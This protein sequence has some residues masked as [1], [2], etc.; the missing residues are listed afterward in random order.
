MVET[1]EKKKKKL[2]AY[3]EALKESL[4]RLEG[5][6]GVKRASPLYDVIAFLVGLIFA[7]CHI[8]FGAHPLAIALLAVLPSH[9]WIT[10][11]GAITGALTLG[12]SGVIYAMISVILV[13]L[14]VIVSG[15]ES[16]GAD[17]EGGGLKLFGESLILKM[18]VSVIGGFVGAVYEVLI[19]G[20]TLTSV[21]FGAAMIV[22]P[23]LIV[24]A[25]SGLFDT[26]ISLRTLFDGTPVFSVKGKSEKERFNLL[27]FKLSSLLLLFLISLSLADLELFGIGA[28]YIFSSA[29]TLAAARRFGPLYGLAVG[30]VTSL[31]LSSTYAVAFAL[32]GAAA[33]ILNK[34]PHIYAV[35]A[36][37]FA[38]G[39]WSIY[40]SGIEGLLST[41]PEYLIAA[42][43]V[44]PLLKKIGSERSDTEVAETQRSAKEM[45]G[46][47]ALSYRNR[48]RGAL[49]SLESSLMAISSSVREYNE[50]AFR[51]SREELY[52]LILECTEKYCRTCSGYGVCMTSEEKPFIVNADELVTILYEKGRLVREEL[53]DYTEQCNLSGGVIDSINRAASIL[54]EEKFRDAA[55]DTSAE[56]FAAVSKLINE[57]RL[58]DEREKAMNEE[59]S[60]RLA[61]LLETVGLPDGVVRAFGDRK[62]YFIIAAEDESGEHITSKEL[63]AGIERIADVKLGT[64]EFYRNGKMA[65]MEAPCEKRFSAECAIASISA[66]GEV[67][68]GDS[69]ASF[70]SQ[71]GFFYTVISDGMGTGS[72]AHETADFVTG[73]LERGLEFNAEGHTVLKILNH[74]VRHRHRECSATVD[75]FSVDLYR[76]DAHF[77]KS[78]AAPSYIKRASSIFRIKSKT[79]PIGLMKSVDAERIRVELE[80]GD[81]IVMLSDGIAKTDDDSPWLLD[82]LAEEP[83]RNP[84]ELADKILREAMRNLNRTDD[85]TVA[86]TRVIR[87]R[88]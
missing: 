19:A 40:A 24:F 23:P 75:L 35:G 54:T 32:L 31:G 51:P 30:F 52:D 85:M 33:G 39:A 38:V 3:T 22:S 78:G 20:F 21:L 44:F 11:V 63:K 34:L 28:G 81:Y 48:Y 68:S 64:P 61:P 43:A 84:R 12:G 69:A 76:G 25:L 6:E 77:L 72:E 46:T 45:V 82:V 4:P 70:E 55:K 29:I 86:V 65:L 67:V 27:F 18:S 73:F 2:G 66:D 62:P 37:A 5:D 50:N 26:G 56:D 7:R 80:S 17:K 49:S 71:G 74:T 88:D 42:M 14:R 59:L 58:D 60:E 57:A 53:G 13:F 41:E 87:V 15:V 36:G 1:T 79:A 8:V 10:L 9:I 83:K 16:R 47:V